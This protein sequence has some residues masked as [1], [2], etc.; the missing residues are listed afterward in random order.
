M[1][2]RKCST[3]RESLWW[4][5]WLV[6]IPVSRLDLLWT[7]NPGDEWTGIHTSGSETPDEDDREYEGEE[8][9]A[10]VTIIEDFDL[11]LFK[12]TGKPITE[13]GEAS[14][15]DTKQEEGNSRTMHA[16]LQARRV[17]KA[18]TMKRSINKTTRKARIKR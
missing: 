3:G 1:R 16:E 5:S 15:L 13:K 7:D 6:I 11:D 10:T 8:H 12:H 4:R 17:N 9:L 18:E 2:S 14:H